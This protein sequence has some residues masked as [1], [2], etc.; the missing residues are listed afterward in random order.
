[1]S[2]PVGRRRALYPVP[3]FGELQNSADTADS[4]VLAEMYRR[5]VEDRSRLLEELEE[6]REERDALARRL[7]ALQD[8]NPALQVRA[9]RT[10]LLVTKSRLAR[11]Q[12]SSGPGRLGERRPS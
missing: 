9:L 3:T 11:L 6:V 10:A 12:I 7:R 4:A 1:M 2:G 8:T 5:G